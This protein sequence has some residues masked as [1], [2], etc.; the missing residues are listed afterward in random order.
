MID[1]DYELKEQSRIVPLSDHV[2]VCGMESG[3]KKLSS[4]IILLDD[5]GKNS[6]IRPRECTVYAIGKNIDYL[7]I[8][9]KILV[10]HGRWS[11]GVRVKTPTGENIVVRRVD[12][13]DIL[14]VIEN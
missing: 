5:D 3:G 2:L 7:E 6:G 8:G 13:A 4:G 11:R 14:L 1:F 9:N 10:A 12:P